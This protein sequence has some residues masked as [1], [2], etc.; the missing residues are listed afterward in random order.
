MIGVEMLDQTALRLAYD[1]ARTQMAS[2][3]GRELTASDH[4]AADVIFTASVSALE[5][6][7]CPESAPLTFV[8]LPTGFGKTTNAIC[9]LAA[10]WKTDASFSGAYLVPTIKLAEEVIAQLEALVG[11]SNAAVYSR[12]H[13]PD[14]DPAQAREA[15]G[16][17]P[18]RVTSRDQLIKTRLIVVTH[19]MWLTELRKAKPFG[20]SLYGNTARSIVYIDESPNLLEVLEVSAHEVQAFIDHVVRID[21]KHPAAGP[22]ASYVNE[23]NR[24]LQSNGKEFE[25]VPFFQDEEGDVFTFDCVTDVRSLITQVMPEQEQTILLEKLERLIRF[26]KAA[27]RSRAF[28]SRLDRTFFAYQ[29]TFKPLPGMVILDATADLSNLVLLQCGQRSVPVPQVDYSNLTIHHHTHPP[30]FRSMSE[31]TAK[32]STGKAYAAWVRSIVL[33]STNPGDDV[34]VIVHKRVLDLEFLTR[35]DNP[36]AP[37]DWEGRRVNLSHWG[38]GVGENKWKAKEVVCLFGEFFQRTATLVAE[39][40]G[41]SGQTVTADRLNAAIPKHIHSNQ[42]A[43]SGEYRS[44]F[45]RHLLRWPKQLA[46][47]GAIRLIDANGKCGRMRLV[48]TM[49]QTRLLQSSN[50]LFPGAKINLVAGDVDLDLTNSTA[51]ARVLGRE[52]GPILTYMEACKA[53]GISPRNPSRM[54]A[55]K[56]VAAAMAA[57]GWRTSTLVR[58]GLKGKG[59]AF[60]RP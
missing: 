14:R 47:R 11:P 24:L 15:L 30:H 7:N 27:R 26:I 33:A 45:N 51:L 31:V 53:A 19:E 5:Q 4:K 57:F 41:Y 3:Q 43:P 18:D 10:A 23:M 32:A 9:F 17:V 6:H 54:V 40:N 29:L 12:F 1:H 52:N 49:D 36:A 48:T 60:V 44:A 25:T 21:S 59:L 37:Q 50:H 46:A 42:Y 20:V 35:S 28:F 22:L 58:A 38:T 34:L 56:P 39:V 8:S 55:T 2:F 13:K 16:Y